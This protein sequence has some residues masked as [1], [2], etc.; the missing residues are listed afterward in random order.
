MTHRVGV[1]EAGTSHRPPQLIAM[2]I[3][4]VP[5]PNTTTRWSR[6]GVAPTL[7]YEQGARLTAPVP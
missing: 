5:A 2:P 4:A 1:V 6:S 7:P 3:P